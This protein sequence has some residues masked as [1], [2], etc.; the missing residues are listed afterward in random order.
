MKLTATAERLSFRSHLALSILLFFFI[1]VVTGATA[2]RQ[3]SA[4]GED[5]PFSP[6]ESD[7][8]TLAYSTFIGGN[9]ADGAQGIALDSQ[10]NIYLA[11]QTFSQDLL[12]Y[13]TTPY[14]Y[15]DIYVAKLDPSGKT[16][17]WVTTIGSK[18]SDKP[19]SVAVDGQGNVYVT[20]NNYADDFPLL[21]PLWDEYPHYSH[22]GA[23]VKLD[24]N[25]NGVYSTLLPLDLFESR[26]SLAVDP[27]GNAY[28]V[29]SDW[30]DD[31]NGRQIGLL[32]I[33]PAGTQALLQKYYGGPDAE[34]GT[35]INLDSAGNIYI[36]GRTESEEFPT[37][38]NAIQKECGDMLYGD[39]TYCYEDGVV[40]VLNPSGD[41]TYSSYHGGSFTDELMSI[42]TDGKGNIVI[43]GNTTSGVFP[44]K[45]A[46]QSSCP[47][48]P[49][50]GDCYFA[51]AFV[52]LM[53]LNGGQASLVYSTY[54]GSS[55][56]YSTNS[57][58]AAT[59]DGSGQAT[60]VGYTNGKVFPTASAFQ[61]ELALGLCLTFS[62]ERFCFDGFVTTFTPT[63][64]L[65]FSSYLGGADDEFPYGV[66][67]GGNGAIYV[68]GVTESVNFPT[69]ADALQP[70]S[71]VND[72]GF[73]SRIGSGV[74]PPPPPPPPPPPLGN[75][76]AFVPGVIR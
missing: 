62:S 28:I 63:G 48:D 73:L 2:L 15:S 34:D 68:G 74:T 71:P 44:L 46:L 49:S 66:R 64:S 21:N 32:K 54:L 51:R 11:G 38:A 50:Y 69:T 9:S 59:I 5:Q 25:G 3:A 16:V 75:Y 19:H 22:N 70:N 60:V 56:N 10:G 4:A 27:A 65:A 8:A 23:L 57:L 33:N 7:A 67:L 39:G 1:L 37:T 20:V 40:M 43:A 13:D 29:G 42:A 41:V 53:R 61:K 30:R 17:K 72:D 26:T 47:I 55:E 58:T 35:A 31:G 12:G 76:N 24:Q 6:V 18:D 14:G 52:S 45:N 36:A